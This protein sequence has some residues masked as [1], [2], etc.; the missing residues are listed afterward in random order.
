MKGKG[1]KG[2]YVRR[3]RRQ[4]RE[5]RRANLRA[6]DEQLATFCMYPPKE[7]HER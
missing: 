4:L 3:I 2:M 6:T 1:K 7:D 5:W